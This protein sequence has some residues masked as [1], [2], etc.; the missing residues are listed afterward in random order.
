MLAI[1]WEEQYHVVR[2]G[3][4][5]TVNAI[6]MVNKKF[7]VYC[8]VGV[9]N[10]LYENVECH[11]LDGLDTVMSSCNASIL[12]EIPNNI[13]KLTARNVKRWWTSHGLPYMT[14]AFRV[15]L[16]VGMLI[17]C[18]SVW[19]FLVLTFVSL[20]RCRRSVLAWVDHESLLTPEVHP[21]ALVR[22]A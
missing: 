17:S 15:E 12:D 19:R 2:Q 22:T 9:L 1:S 5:S 6:A 14:D 4:L 7:L 10:M 16:E 11:H 13:V 18:C 8:L 20:S 3:N 21:R